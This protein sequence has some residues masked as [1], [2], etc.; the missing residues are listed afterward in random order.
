LTY[1]LTSES[2]T[3]GHPDKLCDY[4]S[5]SILDEC[6]S[7]DPDARV[8]VEVFV[9]GLRM[10]DSEES[11]S[12]IIIGGEVSIRK[13]VVIEYENIA[14]RAAVE[15]GY[16]SISKGM[17]AN[18]YDKCK[19][20]V[21]IGEQST[22]ISQGVSLGQGIDQDQGAG[23]QGVM[24][25]FASRETEY[26][27]K[28][29]G[30]YMPLPIILAH[31]LTSKISTR[32]SKGNFEW[33]GPDGKSQVTVEYG[34]DDIPK[35]VKNVI[36]A[37]QHRDLATEKF[38]G[39]VKMEREHIYNAIENIVK[40]EIPIDLICENMKLVVNGTGRF[41]IGGPEGDAGLTGRKIIVDTYGGIGRHGG[42]AFSGKDP[43]KVDRSAAYMARFVA[44]H[45]VASGLADKCEIQIA[46][47]IGI[48]K[49]ISMNL[50]VNTLGTG[51]LKDKDIEKRVLQFFDFRPAKII[52]FLKL[53]NPI[54]KKTSS[55]GHFGRKDTQNGHFP[56]EIIDDEILVKLN[57]F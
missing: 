46:Y 38:D 47:G 45:I 6:L 28:L 26:F 11:T 16:D 9:K 44:K 34:S 4:I 18:N 31:R 8:A 36:I 43:S 3:S 21:L 5:D 41:L 14:R 54:Y 19:V 10:K 32:M 29:K 42:G 30:A 20:L 52:E 49:P 24:Y 13:G 50:N 2:V 37:I 7:K 53:K 25:G 23:D 35:K 56:W 51:V 22:Y 17:D 57:N 40:G 33:A 15:I 1:L 27:E 12:H 48:S 39:S 55:G